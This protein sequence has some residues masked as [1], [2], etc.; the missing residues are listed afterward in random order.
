MAS[1]GSELRTRMSIETRSTDEELIYETV[2]NHFKR[3]KVE[4]SNAIKKAF[5]FLEGLRDRE[6][7]TN[8]MYEDFQD[9]CRNLVPVPRVVYKVLSDLEK[10]FSLPLLEALFS[11]VN[12]QEYPDLNHI[13]KS[14]ET[15]IQ[16]KLNHEEADRQEGEERT[17]IQLRLGQGTDKNSFQS[18]TWLSRGI[19]SSDGTTTPENGLSEHLCEKEQINAKRRDTISNEK[20][21]L[22][23]Q[24]ANE[25]DAQESEPAGSYEQVHNESD[26]GDTGEEMP[27]PLPS[28]EKSTK[29]SN[30]GLQINSCSVYLVDIKK[31]KPFFNSEFEWQPQA[32][33]I[34]V[35]SSE[36]SAE[37][38]DGEMS[39]RASRSAQKTLPGLSNTENKHFDGISNRKRRVISSDCSELS[40]ED[41]LLETA[42]PVQR[43][44]SDISDSESSATLGNHS[45]KR[46]RK[47]GRPK[48]QSKRAPQKRG[49]PRG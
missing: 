15:V 9:S 35:I 2:F 39:L 36:D 17:N 29:L 14:F 40:D 8:K 20:D 33:D 4:I 19:S 10:K 13:Y 31:E 25:Q 5:P 28:V 11:E 38:S 41:I 24:Q 45:G 32:T 27:D 22:E 44:R 48:T 23:S 3:H 7:I 34:I 18:L 30:Q 16:E 49:R 1:G 42:R 47:R 37:S 46:M 43:N 6:L 26:N 12:M 21:E